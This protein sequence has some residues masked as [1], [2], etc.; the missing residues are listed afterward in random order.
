[1]KA[2]PAKGG[3][4]CY[5]TYSPP[6]RDKKQPAK[7]VRGRPGIPAWPALFSIERCIRLA[8]RVVGCDQLASRTVALP[9]NVKASEAHQNMDRT[10]GKPG[11]TALWCACAR[12][13]SHARWKQHTGELVTPYGHVMLHESR[14]PV[15]RSHGSR[16]LTRITI[17]T[18][19]ARSRSKP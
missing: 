9:E 1:M 10:A 6:K 13:H 8:N 12:C 4:D 7:T 17:T 18:M 19:P 16:V 5:S 11:P 3:A 14:T 15:Q 2:G